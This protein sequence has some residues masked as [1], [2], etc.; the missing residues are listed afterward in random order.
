MKKI[1]VFEL[2]KIKRL[3]NRAVI[4]ILKKKGVKKVSAITYVSSDA[5]DKRIPSKEEK[6][7]GGKVSHLFGAVRRMSIATAPGQMARAAARPDESVRPASTKT[8]SVKSGKRVDVADVIKKP[9]SA[10]RPAG[11]RQTQPDASQ[12]GADI[13]AGAGLK[14]KG[15]NIP[16]IASMVLS[17]ILM[18]VVG[19][20]YFDMRSERARFAGMSVSMDR[21]DKTVAANSA[22]LRDVKNQVADANGRID[23]LKRA[24]WTSRLKSQSAVL[25]ALS[26]SLDEPLRSRTRTLASRLAEF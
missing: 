14:G 8:H 19:Y 22:Q 16:A 6:R 9:K 4:E 24:S 20:L 13:K 1:R 3:S 2:A 26:A 7:H 21:I 12:K 11:L 23:G 15:W 25:G 17:A 10:A 5:L 18:V